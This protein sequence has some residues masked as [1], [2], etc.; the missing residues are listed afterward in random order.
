MEWLLTVDQA[1][2]VRKSGSPR[3]AAVLDIQAPVAAVDCNASKADRTEATNAVTVQVDEHNHSVSAL[4]KVCDVFLPTF[5]TLDVV[6]FAV[7]VSV[8]CRR[9]KVSFYNARPSLSSWNR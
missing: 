9:S 3:V 2:Y 4:D 8:C 7:T 1:V 5:L 6:S